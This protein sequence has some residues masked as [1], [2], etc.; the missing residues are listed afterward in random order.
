MLTT[1]PGFRAV[2]LDGARL[3]FHPKTGTHVRVAG[4]ATVALRRVAPRV[5]MFGITNACNLRCPFCS[6]DRARDSEWTVATAAAAL[7]GLAAAGTL[8]VAFG[9]G[10][11]FAFAGFADL[12]AELAETTPLAMHVTTNGTLIDERSWAPLRGRLG[13]VRIS[14]YD[15]PR[16]RTAAEVLASAGQRW[17]ANVLVDDAALATLPEQLAALAAHGSR[18]VSILTYIGD[19]ARQLSA[20]GRLRLAAILARSPLPAR[21]SVCAGDRIPVPR[22]FD[23]VDG[24]GDCGAGYDFV[25]ITPDRRLQ[26]CSFQDRGLARDHE[27][28][29]RTADEI[30]DGWRTAQARLSRPSA[31]IGC[32]R[33]LPTLSDRRA[34]QPPPAVTIWQAFSGNNSGECIL[35]A[36]F[37]AAASAEAYL[38]QLLPDYAPDAPFPPAWRA[39]FEQEQVA[40]PRSADSDTEW[41]T[42]PAE[43][44]AIGRTVIAV[45]HDAGDAFPEL[46]ALAWK[47]GG[48]VVPGGIHVHDGI[49]VLAAI[50]A[51]SA[52]DAQ[53]VIAASRHPRARLWHHGD[54]VIAAIPYA[55]HA[56]KDAP[57]TLAD[58]RA[59]LV[60]LASDRP[61]AA[62]LV[63]EPFTDHDLVEVLQRLGVTLAT[64][65]RLSVHFWGGEDRGHSR[66]VAWAASLHDQ[67]STVIGSTVLIDGVARPKRLAVLAHRRD[68][69]VS[70][71]SGRR[72][73]V[74]AHLW[75]S[76][77]PRQSQGQRKAVPR[78]V[79]GEALIDHLSKRPDV[80]E[81]T[82]Q[83]SWQ[84]VQLTL[85]TEQPAAVAR[86]VESYARALGCEL[87]V[88]FVEHSP[89]TWAVRR[90][91]AELDDA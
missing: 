79:D 10:E 25:S 8:E 24:T 80:D 88:G 52:S 53:A 19:S 30:L 62:E 70:V 16:W 41:S 28:P 73:R 65:T 83:K 87:T 14:I 32:A 29:A 23:G 49:S 58:A 90:L 5:A 38:A 51:A 86:D 82:V 26:A 71:L 61:H 36:T 7:R 50:R 11:P 34:P 6:R 31:R 85:S 20:D 69:H 35:V 84:G 9:G 76:P 77:P 63:V 4:P 89:L 40:T 78:E 3:Y 45:G 44:I 72:V 54:R 59:W 57:N 39:M 2:P 22:L 64:R 17:G 46:R 60:T 91:L 13:I 74:R 15:D 47:R 55:D 18:D 27:L 68:G 56:A 21:L 48:T 66:A 12:I 81:A 37:E 33:S 43:M 42:C 1:L 67:P 75:F